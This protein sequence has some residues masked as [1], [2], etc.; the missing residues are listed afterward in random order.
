MHVCVDMQAMFSEP[1]D[2]H[3]PWMERVLPAVEAI[4]GQQPAKTVFTRFI[5]PASAA[6]APGAWRKYYER[7]ESM[8]RDRLPPALLELV[9]TLARHVPP[10][11][12]VD[13]PVYSPWYVPAL[14]SY[15]QERNTD[16]LIVTGGETDVCVLATVLGAIDHGYRVVVPTD[17]VFSSA[18]AT[19]DA[20]IGIYHSRFAMQLTACGT[21]DI[22]DEWKD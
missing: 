5:P 4:V 2:W 11:R 8:T 17:A 22:L 12:I 16:T 9:P 18:D 1:T 6:A 20:M 7:W 3:A 19:H 10:A 15:L 13:K 14:H 21:Q